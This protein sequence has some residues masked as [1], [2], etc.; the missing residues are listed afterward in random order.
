MEALLAADQI[1]IHPMVIGELAMGMLRHRA[2]R[3]HELS[4]LPQLPEVHH[5]EVMH[6]VALHSYFGKGIGFIDAHLL[7]A[8]KLADDV[9]LYTDD[10]RLRAIAEDLGIAYRQARA[11]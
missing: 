9:Q 3:L 8:A 6:F 11:V 10:K 7:L 5:D 1:V 2:V 4:K